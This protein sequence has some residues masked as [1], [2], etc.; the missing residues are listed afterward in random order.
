MQEDAIPRDENGITD[1]VV[2]AD[3]VGVAPGVVLE[4]VNA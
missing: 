1:T 2:D 4:T 3:P